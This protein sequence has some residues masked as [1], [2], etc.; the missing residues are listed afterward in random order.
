MDSYGKTFNFESYVRFSHE[1]IK[2]EPNR[3]YDETGKWIITVEDLKT[4]QKSDEVFDGVIICS[5]YYTKPS[6]PVFKDQHIF[7][8]DILHSH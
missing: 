8:G 3:D 4:G 5:G 1:V 6:I 7:R 2:V